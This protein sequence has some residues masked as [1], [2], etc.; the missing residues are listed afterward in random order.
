MIE[1]PLILMFAIVGLFFATNAKARDVARAY[2]KTDTMRKQF[3]LLDDS[4]SMKSIK[5]IR[6]R[7]KL[8]FYRSY[9]FEYNHSDFQ[10]YN[11]KIELL[12]YQVIK[13]H[14]FHTNH[15]EQ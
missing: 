12:G 7:G 9:A 1:I 4:I 6:K 15:I 13:I 8:G 14:Y 10:R 11:G 5:I 2:C 3:V